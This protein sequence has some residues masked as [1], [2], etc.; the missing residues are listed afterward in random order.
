MSEFTEI[1][2]QI[3]LATAD[4]YWTY[5][6]TWLYAEWQDCDDSPPDQKKNLS[7]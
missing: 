6:R 3:S 2:Q 4:R 5:A 1:L 7:T